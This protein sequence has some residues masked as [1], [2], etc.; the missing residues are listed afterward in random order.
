MKKL[1]AILVA[2]SCLLAAVPF[3]VGEGAPAES[4]F[5]SDL[6]ARYAEP[7]HSYGTELRWWLAEGSHTD[8]TL[9]EEIHAIYDAGF[10]GIELCQLDENVLDP[11][12]YAYGSDQWNHDVHLILREALG[13]GLRVALT[14]GTNWST[15]NIPGLDPDSQAASQEVGYSY[16]F[17]EAGQTREGPLTMPGSRAEEGVDIR[18]DF[19]GCYAYRC[20]GTTEQ[21]YTVGSW[22]SDLT[23]RTD[24][25]TELDPGSLIDL[26]GEVVD[27]ELTWTAPDDGTYVITAYWQQGAYQAVNPAAETCYT[28]NYFDIEGFEALKAYWEEHLFGDEELVELMKN[29]DVQLFMDSLEYSTSQ[30]DNMFWSDDMAEE[31]IARKGYDIRPYLCLFIGSPTMTILEPEPPSNGLFDFAGEEGDLLRERIRNDL[32]DVHSELY[33]ENLME[34]LR[35]WLNSYNVKLRAQIS[36]GRQIEIS[37]PIMTV[38]YPEAENLNQADQPDV[39]RMWTGGA[40]LQ[41]KVLSSE[42]GAYTYYNYA[43]SLQDYLQQAYTLY[44]AGFNRIIWHGW[45]A[46]YGPEDNTAW[47]GY[48]GMKD[49]VA[50]R[51][52]PREPAYETYTE[53]NAHLARVQQLLREGTSQTDLG[54]LYISYAHKMPT[55]G[56]HDWLLDH[57]PILWN[58]MGLQD[59]GYTYD[60]FSPEFL[61]ADGVSYDAETGRLEQAGYKAI[62]LFQEELPL[63]GA[64]ALLEYA[65]QGLK[66][67]ILDGAAT[68]T[69]YNDGKDAELAAVIEEMKALDNVYT[70]A[71]ETEAEAALRAA[72]IVPSAD[73][74]EPNA[75]LL[76]QMRRVGDDRYLYVYNYCPDTYCG[77]DH[78]TECVT[79]IAVEGTFIPYQID[80]WTGEVSKVAE[81]RHEDGRTIIP[82]DLIYGDIALYA[83]E[84][85]D[86]EEAHVVSAT[87]DVYEQ[88]GVFYLRAT[89]SGEYSVE[90]ADGT[91]ATITAEVPEAVSLTNWQLTVESWSNSGI[92][93][94]R[95]ETSE[96]GVTTTE[97]T[98][99]TAKTM[100]PLTLETLTTWDNIEKVGKWVSGKGYYSTTFAWDGAADGAY[101]DLGSFDQSLTVYVNGVKADPVNIEN[102]VLDISDLLVEGENRLDITYCS[103][104]T[105]RVKADGDQYLAR[106]VGPLDWRNVV[107]SRDWHASG[108]S[109]VTL[110]PYV[111]HEIA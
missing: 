60:Y 65:K 86:A 12:V 18:Q 78:G 25:V 27:G 98:Y 42:T 81:Y 29:G 46:M 47:P 106:P 93:Q 39:Y 53:F 54:M 33:M 70:I 52:S 4:D 8:E 58:D 24:T 95:S 76:T 37:E 67:F 90:M 61:T 73:F 68:R 2:L 32:Y 72:G 69:P 13:L 79:E 83:F 64:Q 74:A 84:A 82:I 21:T 71:D 6:V 111:D 7:D 62:M 19:L 20:E 75:Q 28:I 15:A 51:F 104:L 105:N 66:V 63:D 50:G 38:D 77:L 41:N 100:I 97:V 40:H 10:S 16:E 17:V 55:F 9:I 102:A 101:L 34:P 85:T 103:T 99:L 5:Y 107:E 88:D 11:A 44:S 56:Y 89:A 36:Y 35:E 14:A 87:G 22:F 31:F 57:R 3:A 48:E 91:A 59:A 23:E 30:G 26:S 45:A 108:L 80:A 43:L 109:S 110:V 92:P 49:M 1:L 96:D 94:W